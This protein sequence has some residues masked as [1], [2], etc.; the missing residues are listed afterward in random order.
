[1]GGPVRAISFEH[2]QSN[3]VMLQYRT[4]GRIENRSSSPRSREGTDPCRFG[5][6]RQLDLRESRLSRLI[7]YSRRQKKS[8]LPFDFQS[9]VAVRQW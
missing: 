8:G 5:A 3:S 2:P 7:L 6:T 4:E 1:M 9:V